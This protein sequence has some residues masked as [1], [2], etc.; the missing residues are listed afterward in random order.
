MST[1]PQHWHEVPNAP[2][3]GTV[4]GALHALADGSAT[5]V[6]LPAAGAETGAPPFRYLLLR[7]GAHAQA[8]V[9]R[10]AHFGVPLAARQE[11][12]IYQPHVRITCNVHY[13]HYRWSDGRCLG[14]ECDG[15]GLLPI[16]VQIDAQGQILVAQPSG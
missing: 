9:N 12:L 6:E 3:P 7:S 8:F 2:A 4:L 11:L 14:G 16:P 1:D 15:A 5:M 10:C 13:A